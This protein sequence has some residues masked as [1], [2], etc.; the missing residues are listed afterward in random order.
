MNYSN[1]KLLLFALI[2]LLTTAPVCAVTGKISADE[3]IFQEK[4]RSLYYTVT[5]S[6]NDPHHISRCIEEK[7]K[8]EKAYQEFI[9]DFMA[10]ITHKSTFESESKIELGHHIPSYYDWKRVTETIALLDKSPAQMPKIEDV[11]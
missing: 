11:D 10:T 6:H 3:K 8:E 5:P 9:A 4:F 2:A 7:I 1:P